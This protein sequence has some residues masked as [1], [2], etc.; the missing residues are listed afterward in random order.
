MRLTAIDLVRTLQKA[1][2]TAYFAGGCVRDMLLG[3]HPKDFDI[4]TDATPDELEAIFEHTIPVGK[5]FGVIMVIQDGH[6][7]E[8]ATFRSDAGYSDGRR[9]DAVVFTNAEEDAKRRD[10]TINGMFYDPV[11]EE[12]HD[13][14]GGQKDL[15]A[16]LIRFI[17][18]PEKRIEEDHLR[19]LRAVR[20]KNQFD[21][22]YDPDTYD[23][24]KKYAPLIKERV[25]A[26]RIRDEFCKMLM[27]KSKPSMAFEDM[28][29][30]GIL[31]L[32]L[33]ELERL[34]GCAQ[35]FEYHHEGD[36]WTH[37]MNAID[38]LAPETP[39]IARLAT[40]FHDIGK[41]DTY[42]LKERIRFDSHASIGSK[43]AAKIM[44]RLNFSREQVD[45]VTWCIE[46]HMMMA[47]FLD[48]ND[49]RLMHW[50]HH[51]QM[52]NLLALMKADAEGTTPTD[53][54]LYNKIE[55]LHRVK[56]KKHPAPP[57]PLLSGEEIMEIAGLKPGARVGELK[58]QLL[59]LQ[60][61]GKIKT[62]AK[63]EKW[64]KENA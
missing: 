51:P 10:F 21:F 55:K 57:K 13:F 6:H 3:L 53:L 36:V 23:A 40:L 11:T 47:S 38:S 2:Y 4:V 34:R 64:L 62:R 19:L 28:S 17:G 56:L 14:V 33:P 35:P 37:T 41:P 1:N 8:I 26:E 61:D 7:F 44:R 22:Q 20:F 25:S 54:S 52:K 45:A 30:L 16:H 24:I 29:H 42:S 59:E 60:I 27:D 9:P 32:I 39:L 50:L 58:A 49:G 63:A 48:M 43:L 31:Q 18:D 12:V 5:K 46:H 15:D